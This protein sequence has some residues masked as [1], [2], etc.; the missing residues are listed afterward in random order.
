MKKTFY[1]EWAYVFGLLALGFSTALMEKADFGLSMVIAPAYILHL[2][3]S[4][5]LPFFSFGMAGYTVEGLLIIA[6][7]AITRKAKWSYLMSFVTAFLYG[8]I[9]DGFVWLIS[10]LPADGMV[11]RLVC[12]VVGVTV[13]A[14]GVSLMFHTYFAPEAYELFVKELSDTYRWNIT[15]CKTCYDCI[16]CAVA[17][18]LS[19]AFF[20]FGEFQGVKLGTVVC[21]LVNGWLIGR[22]S[23]LLERRFTFVDRLKARPFFTK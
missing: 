3:L 12:Y 14:L 10:G 6:L 17:V 1:T 11:I 20:G 15:T 2:K 22:F 21:A 19:F 4:Q 7:I 5:F 16:S 23:G 13:C 18:C 9:L 8:W